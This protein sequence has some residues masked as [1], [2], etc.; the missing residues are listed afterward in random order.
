[1]EDKDKRLLRALVILW[2]L[3]LIAIVAVVFTFTLSL[4]DIKHKLDRVTNSQVSLMEYVS[5][6]HQE[7]ATLKTISPPTPIVK[8]GVDGEPGQSIKGPRGDNGRDGKDGKDGQ[9]GKDGEPGVPGR[10]ILIAWNDQ[11]RALERHFP[12]DDTPETIV[13]ACDIVRDCKAKNGP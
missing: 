3:T 9:N 10:D 13:T 2:V 4:T 11:T 7:L 6:A 8:D 1:M 5:S 12:G